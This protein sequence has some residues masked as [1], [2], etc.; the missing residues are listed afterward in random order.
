MTAMTIPFIKAHGAGNDFLLSWR[1]QVPAGDLALRKNAPV[2]GPKPPSS[3]ELEDYSQRWRPWR[4]YAA[5]HLWTNI[6]R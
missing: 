1:D 3:G 4:A 2:P 5:M 6:T